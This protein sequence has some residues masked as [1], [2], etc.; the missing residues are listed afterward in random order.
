MEM[1][2]SY[3]FTRRKECRL[4]LYGRGRKILLSAIDGKFSNV[5]H[6]RQLPRSLHFARQRSRRPRTAGGQSNFWSYVF[7]R[8]SKLQSCLLGFEETKK[9]KIW[10]GGDDEFIFYTFAE[11]VLTGRTGR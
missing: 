7:F 10:P 6:E 2:R 8:R 1:K 9:K 4:S 3:G 5:A 11:S